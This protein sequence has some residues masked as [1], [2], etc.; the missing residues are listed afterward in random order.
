MKELMAK[1]HPVVVQRENVKEFMELKMSSSIMML[2][3]AS[4]SL[5]LNSCP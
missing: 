4:P 2:Q 1:F 3:Y 5:S